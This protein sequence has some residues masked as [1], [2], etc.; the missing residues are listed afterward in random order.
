MGKLIQIACG[1]VY[2]NDGTEVS[3]PSSPRIDET[4]SIIESAEGKVIVFVPY[5]SSVNMVAKELSADFSVEVIHGGVKKA[6][7]DRIFRAFQSSKRPK[8]I[9]R[10][11]CGYVSRLNSNSREYNY[12]V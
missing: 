5:V 11:T 2:A 7:R 3:I 6:E 4:R 12:L 9:S 8:S 10:T 1:V